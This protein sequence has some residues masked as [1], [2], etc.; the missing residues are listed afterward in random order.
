MN[1]C[2]YYFFKKIVRT[3][4]RKSKRKVFNASIPN[5]S[6]NTIRINNNKLDVERVKREDLNRVRVGDIKK[7]A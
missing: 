3:F 5:N 7:K 1:I 2:S 6:E 4:L